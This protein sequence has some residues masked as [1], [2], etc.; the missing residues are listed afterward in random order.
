MKSLLH[1]LFFFLLLTQICFAQWVQVGLSGETIKDIAVTNE[2]I[3]AVTNDGCYVYGYRLEVCHGKLYRSIDNGLNWQMIID[4]NVVDVA[5]SPTGKVFVV[6]DSVDNV[7]PY[8]KTDV[9]N[10]LDNGVN[11][12]KINIT[13][14]IADSLYGYWNYLIL[15]FTISPEGIIYSNIGCWGFSSFYQDIIARSIDD[16]NTW[17]TPGMSFWIGRFL[18]FRNQNTI[19]IGYDGMPGALDSHLYLSTDNGNNWSIIKRY[20][21]TAYYC[22]GYFSNGNIIFDSYGEGIYIVNV[23]DTTFN[24]THISYLNPQTGQSFSTGLVEGMLVGTGNL[25]VFLFSDEG[26][27]LGSR[28]EG[29]TNLNIQTLSLDNNGY[30]YAGTGSGIWRR[31]LSEVTSLK[32]APTQPTDFILEQ[33]YPNPFNPSTKISWQSPIGSHQTIKVFDVLGNEITTLVDEF[34]PAGRYEVEFQS[35]VGS[36]HLASGIYFYQ[37]SAGSFV[38]TKKMILIR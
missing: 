36:R 12:A 11:W 23:V 22:L 34:K 4:S 5:I 26:D 16:G 2:T 29:L 35:S 13:E 25:G 9:F 32:D 20:F 24:P 17:S 21:P 7:K 30:V 15:K 27:S 6:K 14:Q 37:L 8:F 18:D 1:S 33:N 3:F 19:S 10:S 38:Q 28:N 31:P